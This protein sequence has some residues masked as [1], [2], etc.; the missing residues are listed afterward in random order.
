MPALRTQAYHN[1]AAMGGRLEQASIYELGG[2]KTKGWYEGTR[3]DH[4]AFFASIPNLPC[5]WRR[6]CGLELLEPC[7]NTL[8]WRV[9]VGNHTGEF[10][11][12]NCSWQSH[13]YQCLCITVRV[14][15]NMP[16]TRG[17]PRRGSAWYA[18]KEQ[19][20]R[21]GQIERALVLATSILTQRARAEEKALLSTIAEAQLGGS[22]L[23]TVKMEES[24]EHFFPACIVEED[25]TL[26]DLTAMATPSDNQTKP[27]RGDG[28]P[29]LNWD[30]EAPGCIIEE[31]PPEQEM[32][33]STATGEVQSDEQQADERI[34][35]QDD[36]M[37]EVRD[38]MHGFLGSEE[39]L[40]LVFELRGHMADLEH[41]ALVMGQRLD[42]LFDAYSDAP[43]RRKCPLCAQPFAIQAGATWKAGEEAR[44]PTT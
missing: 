7:R 25:L 15:G 3:S 37:P 8:W 1:R 17:V 4:W 5:V 18:R 41:R 28:L 35:R 30:D 39:H 21:R 23:N 36:R 34:G 43:D 42:V 40:S 6:W 33:L 44:S 29:M 31:E 2:C 38:D 11:L 13:G 10:P 26:G 27:R 24:T 14:P 22:S 12:E 20:K 9:S 32:V 16:R 19:R